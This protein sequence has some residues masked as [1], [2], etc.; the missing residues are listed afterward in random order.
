MIDNII[1]DVSNAIHKRIADESI[2]Q[3][4]ERNIVLGPAHGESGPLRLAGSRYLHEPLKAFQDQEVKEI[5]ILKPT[6]T[7]GTM[8]GEVALQWSMINRPGSFQWLCETDPKSIEQMT[9]RIKPMML[10]NKAL[11]PLLPSDERSIRK[12][13]VEI[14]SCVFKITGTALSNLQS[15]TRHL[16]IIDELGYYDEGTILYEIKARTGYTAEK[17]NSKILIISQA[18]FP[19]NELDVAWKQG[20]ME[21]WMV[22]CESCGKYISPDIVHFT[23]EGKQFNDEELHLKD[24]K[25]NYILGKLEKVLT[26]DCPYCQH[27]HRD[28]PKL[29]SY[30]NDNG[31]Y[32]VT[33]H[34][35]L[36]GHRSFHWTAIHCTKWIDLIANWLKVCRLRKNGDNEEFIKFFQKRLARPINPAEYFNKDKVVRTDKPYDKNGWEDEFTRIFTI[37]VQKDKFFGGIRAWSKDGRSRQLWSGWMNTID[38]VLEK[39]SEFNIPFALDKAGK[40]TYFVLWDSGNPA[41][42]TEIFNYCVTYNHLAIKGDTSGTKQFD[43]WVL[44]NNKKVNKPRPWTISPVRGDPFAGMKNQGKGPTCQVIIM[45]TDI[46]KKVLVQLR[47]G[48]GPEWLCLSKDDNPAFD[49]YNTGMFNEEFY[50]HDK[51]GKPLKGGRWEKINKFRT[52]ESFDV[53]N[54]NLGAAIMAGVQ[55]DIL[56]NLPSNEFIKAHTI[57]AEESTVNKK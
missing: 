38:Q 4:A 19:D 21:E 10:G 24:D 39:Q 53:E 27:Q 5:V 29:K 55:I 37:D 41:R 18:G 49:D 13:G 20:T 47:D 46:L 54:Y 36:K 22:P 40:K 31:R 2:L 33:N 25:N 51:K 34:D 8:V 6:Q 23:A 7:G 48:K 14:A 57:A 1:K 50:T 3:W 15:A 44:L 11:R 45:A 16:L 43:H 35:H 32:E 52:N 42:Q 30:W 12:D 9:A 28:T 17:G 56:N 26:F